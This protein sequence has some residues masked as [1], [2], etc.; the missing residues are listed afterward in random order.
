MLHITALIAAKSVSIDIW[1]FFGCYVAQY[2]SEPE[3]NLAMKI[4]EKPAKRNDRLNSARCVL[5]EKD[6]VANP[7]S[8]C[9]P[10]S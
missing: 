9:N 7:L 1:R 8:E 6:L 3:E 4:L 2:D 5:N 10:G